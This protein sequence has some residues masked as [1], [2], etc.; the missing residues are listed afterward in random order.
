MNALITKTLDYYGCYIYLMKSSSFSAPSIPRW[1]INC[2]VGQ[3]SG[4]WTPGKDQILSVLNTKHGR[5]S[6][7]PRWGHPSV[8][9]SGSGLGQGRASRE[10]TSVDVRVTGAWCRGLCTTVCVCVHVCMCMSVRVC[11]LLGGTPSK[12][13]GWMM[14][15]RCCYV[16]RSEH[17][18][19]QNQPSEYNG[20]CALSAAL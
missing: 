2:I 15:F 20:F 14:P 17:Q 19:S 10:G 18:Y 3:Q 9:G 16:C 5:F 8:Q 11:T 12:S 1:V 7:P 6:G 13:T 4:W